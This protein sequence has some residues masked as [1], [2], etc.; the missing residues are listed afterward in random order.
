MDEVEKT[1]AQSTETEQVEAFSS[2]PPFLER[3]RNASTDMDG[4]GSPDVP[5]GTLAPGDQ[6]E[7]PD[8]EPLEGD[9]ALGAAV[10][11]FFAEG[12]AGVKEMNAARRAHAQARDGLERLGITIA[13]RERELE[14]RRDIE[15]RYGDI[16]AEETDRRDDAVTAKQVA[17]Q[18]IAELSGE[19]AQARKTLEG[20]READSTTERRLKSAL[21]AAE[22]KEKSAREQGRR[23]Q[24]RLDDAKHN[25]DQAKTEREEGIAAAQKA[26]ESA[27]SLLATLNREF[28]DLQ[29]T[30]SAN[31][32][33][34]SVRTSQLEIE[35]SDAIDALH[36]AQDDL[37][38]VQ[39]ETQAAV[40]AAVAAV[41]E[42]ERPIEPAK[43]SFEAIAA[44]ADDAR[45]AYGTAKDET[46]A[47]QKEQ[48]R[49]ISALEKQSK[50]QQRIVKEQQEVIDAAQ[51]AM[52][53]ADDIHAHP[54]ATEALAR[55]LEADR[56][57][58]LERTAEVEE[59][60]AAEHAVRERTRDSRT[61]LALFAAGMVLA[62][63]L[64]IVWLNIA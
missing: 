45:D 51:A 61:R 40:E 41:K 25:L 23:L 62:I 29:R 22:D 3:T 30:P 13:E 16:I 63:I 14:H 26:I 9:H 11:G 34:Y 60:A 50:E 4:M 7:V 28:A 6:P 57:E 5:E 42:A 52:D 31:P 46:E 32:A 1:G 19:I 43:A 17:E 44:A 10:G 24:R 49:V 15:A 27:D 21:E 58:R 56:S 39:R 12:V 55:A 8:E 59:L 53:E 54:E 64:F 20:M 18:R 47:R 48:R 36:L 33:E 38:R 37:P 2:M 35:I